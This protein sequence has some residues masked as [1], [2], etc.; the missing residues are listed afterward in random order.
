[1]RLAVLVAVLGF[2]TVARADT[3]V[4][5]P[6][7]DNTIYGENAALSDG[8][9]QH[10]FAGLTS[11][12]AERRALIEFDVAGAVPPG[13][14]ITSV[15]LTLRLDRT[16]SNTTSV[17]VFKVMAD[18][19]EG[20]SLAGGEE[21][22]GGSAATG[23]AT[24]SDR[25]YPA[26]AW[27]TAGGDIAATASATT[28]IGPNLTDYTWSG[29]A[30]VADVQGWLD[31]PAT[32]HG[33]LLR[34]P[35]AAAGEASGSRAAIARDS[36]VRPR[37]SITFTPPLPTGACCAPDGSCTVV[38][39]PGTTCA[40]TLQ[41]R[42][43]DVHAEPCP[44]PSGACCAARR[45]RRVHRGAAGPVQPATFHGVNSTCAMPSCPVVLTPFVDPLPILP[46][47][48]STTLS[49]G[50]A[51]AQGP[52]RPATDDAVGLRRRHRR[53]LARP[54]DR[55]ARRHAA[56]H[57]VAE[58]LCPR[59]HVL[60]V[61]RCLAPDDVPRSIIHLHGGHVPAAS[62]G[63]PDDAVAPGGQVVDH[64][65]NNQERG[66]A[67]VPR[68]RDGHHAAQRDDGPRRASICCAMTPRTRS[69]C[70]RA[71]TRSR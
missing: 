38:N 59:A 16:Q 15:T 63:Y 71:R 68:P 58:R 42:Q 31:T 21:G 46:V 7:Q 39:S 28:S 65:P 40:T 67:L 17:A 6:V 9:G 50:P 18:W 69:A 14:T 41:R 35:A 25:F 60:G 45:D 44:Q 61:D 33:W 43:H 29:A 20:A 51:A 10:M 23:D 13:S 53:A 22:G 11:Q 27:A 24:W 2:S 3:V 56:R 55:G 49:R 37:L 32:N 48:Q 54:D 57:H 26:T 30:M 70:P 34:A 12:S 19:G 5:A 36:T 62:D 1:M 64:Y 8:Q 4:L 66:D 52:P 47:A